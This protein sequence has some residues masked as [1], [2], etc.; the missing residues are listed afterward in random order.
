MKT[1]YNLLQFYIVHPNVKLF[2]S[3]GG[4]SGVYEAVDAGVPVIGFPLFYDQPRNIANLVDAGM[5]ISL[6]LM[7]ITKNTLLNA[8]NDIVSNET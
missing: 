4:I 6:D 1:N 7:S 2:I 8:I 5:A 3:H